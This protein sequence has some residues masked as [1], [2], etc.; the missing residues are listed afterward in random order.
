MTK[1]L[2]LIRGQR[3]LNQIEE[4]Y[5]LDEATYAEL[6]RNTLNFTPPSTKRQWAVDPIQVVNMELVPAK[7]SRNL[8]AKAN[9][10]SNGTQY[11]TT[12]LFDDVEYEEEDQPN[13]VSFVGSNGDEYHIQPINLSRN[14]V[15]VYCNC[16]D[17]YW[18]FAT[19]NARVDSLAGKVPPLYQKKTNR[20]DA[21][22]KKVPGVCKHLMKTVIAL[23]DSG[24]VI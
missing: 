7:E 9:I 16:L 17:F 6:E 13:N 15:K 8:T 2:H 19:Y 14:N 12:V 4:L 20:P 24:L 18:R 21:N 23:R 11:N 3:I 5:K 22:Q 1:K 10:N